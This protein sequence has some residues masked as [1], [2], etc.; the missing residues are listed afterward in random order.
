MAAEQ[1]DCVR[2]IEPQPCLNPNVPPGTQHFQLSPIS[3]VPWSPL[4][5]VLVLER[6]LAEDRLEAAISEL[7]GWYPVL[8]GRY[9]SRPRPG[10]DLSDYA[11]RRRTIH[12]PVS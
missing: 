9:V 12:K 10:A 8:A 6:R 3:L 7:A 11:V 2:L 5:S 1:T 4:P